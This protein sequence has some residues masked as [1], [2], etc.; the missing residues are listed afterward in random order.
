MENDRSVL[1]SF[2]ERNKKVTI[3]I[4][5]EASDL[6]FLSAECLKSFSFDSHVNVGLTFQKYDAD[7]DSFVDLEDDYIASHK[8][9]LKM[10]AIPVLQD[11]SPCQEP[12]FGN[13]EVSIGGLHLEYFV[14]TI[15]AVNVVSNLQFETSSATRSGV[16]T[17][18]SDCSS[19]QSGTPHRRRL[20]HDDDDDMSVPQGKRLQ[21]IVP[22]EEESSICSLSSGLLEAVTHKVPEQPLPDP[23]PLPTNFRPDVEHALRSKQM[24]KEANRA[25]MSSIAGTMFTFKKYPTKEY[26]RVALDVIREYGSTLYVG[27]TREKNGGRI[28]RVH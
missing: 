25:L 13:A 11:C 10:V 4:G 22:V 15:I 14:V 16:Y 9:K 26:T 17:S 28:K 7:W 1:V 20:C 19:L 23:S 2:L 3:P 24:T 12:S 6:S 8:D 18:T 21:M 5:T 27:M